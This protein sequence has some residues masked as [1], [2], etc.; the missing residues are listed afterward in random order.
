MLT[1]LK[2]GWNLLVEDESIFIH[3]SITAKQRRW[4]IKKKRPVVTVTGS[5]EKTIIY[6]ALSLD[7][8]QFFRQHERFDSLSFI[9]YLE[10]V[11]KKFR[12]VIMIVDREHLNTDQRQ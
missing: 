5:H 4:I 6:G 11:R 10:K 12:K 1:S 3:D 9:A 8:K 7:G 2:S